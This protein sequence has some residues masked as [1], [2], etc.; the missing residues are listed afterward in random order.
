MPSD[1]WFLDSLPERNRY[2]IESTLKNH[3]L[4]KLTKYIWY[5]L[6]LEIIWLMFSPVIM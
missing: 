4:S 5:S 6:Y 1:S 2:F 3:I